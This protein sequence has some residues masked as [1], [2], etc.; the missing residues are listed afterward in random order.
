MER[1]SK[2]GKI[3]QEDWPSIM[4][5]Y[6]A[7]ETLASI[8]RTYDCSPPAISY[9]VSRSRAHRAAPTEEAQSTLI[10]TEPQLIKGHPTETPAPDVPRSAAVADGPPPRS[11]T[12][13][14]PDRV[15]GS[16]AEEPPLAGQ[17]FPEEAVPAFNPQHN[18]SLGE[19]DKSAGQYSSAQGYANETESANSPRLFDRA[20]VP[21]RN[22]EPRRTLHL[23]MSHGNDPPPRP[24]LPVPTAHG[25]NISDEGSASA[26][27]QQSLAASGRSAASYYPPA[28]NGAADRMVSQSSLAKGGAAFIDQALRERVEIDITV[29]LA[30][31]DTALT[32]DTP[33]S[34]AGLREATDRLLRAGA[35]T[36]IELERLEARVPLTPRNSGRQQDPAGR[37]R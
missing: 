14:T 3:P 21:V 34:R 8:A 18:A 27:G 7:G 23:S 32:H 22:S 19:G 13:N 10:S 1:S 9:I 11:L 35:R 28:G 15:E 33:E 31:F 12:A 17:A 24:E 26:E 2:R 6:E 16:P 25:A 29:F 30:A 36:R 5:R 20:T 37:Q 4:A